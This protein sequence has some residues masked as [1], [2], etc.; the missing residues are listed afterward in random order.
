MST[1][2]EILEHNRRFVA[3]EAYRDYATTKYPH[4]K[5]VVLTCMD[6]RL[7]E[8]VPRAMNLRNGDVKIVKNAGAIVSHP[9]G[10]IMRSILIAIYQ[11]GA[12]VVCVV[13]HHDCGMT[14]LRPETV[15]ERAREVGVPD[16]TIQT[17]VHA[18][19]DLNRWLTGFR[20]VPESVKQSVDLIKHHPLLPPGI[21]VHGLVI[22]PE[23][24]KLDVVVVDPVEAGNTR[25]AEQ[26]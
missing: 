20:D 12:R 18:G 14:G 23:T 2:D 24:G 11:L 16:E 17:L 15:L 19:I 13:G 9:F 6:T 1:L 22:H 4:K 5:L 26:R 10:S 21:A 25:P 3:T 8:L 7:M